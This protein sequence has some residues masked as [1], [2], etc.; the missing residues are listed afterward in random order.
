M[1]ALARRGCGVPEQAGSCGSDGVIRFEVC[2]PGKLEGRLE[3]CVQVCEVCDWCF[4]YYHYMV[5]LLY[6]LP[7]KECNPD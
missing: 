6:G 4:L 5:S 3:R 2:R 7:V 1:R